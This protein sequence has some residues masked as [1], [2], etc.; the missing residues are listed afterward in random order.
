LAFKC[1]FI[2]F[3][4]LMLI[5][6]HIFEILKLNFWVKMVFYHFL[7]ILNPKIFGPIIFQDL[8]IDLNLMK[9]KQFGKV[10]I[11]NEK[12]QLELR[13]RLK[14]IRRL[15]H[16]FHRF[17]MFWR[18]NLINFYLVEVEMDFI[19]HLFINE[20]IIILTLE[21]LVKRRKVSS[22]EVI[23]HVNGIQ[24]MNGKVMINW[25]IFFSLWR[26]H[27]MLLPA[28][29]HSN[30]TR[31]NI[32]SYAIPTIRWFGLVTVVSLISAITAIQTTNLIIVVL[33]FRNASLW[34]TR[35]YQD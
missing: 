6:H 5:I 12:K 19:Q 23:F 10:D 35:N 17:S 18:V 9:M 11:L 7:N 14:L 21:R 31:D 22:L 32:Q 1:Y 4:H 3:Y 30:R 29:F 25:R 27:I 20:L 34:M 8:L 26:I 24:A 33:A 2:L 13:L 15:F 16:Q 28:L